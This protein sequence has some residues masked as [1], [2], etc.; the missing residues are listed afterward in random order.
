MIQRI[1]RTVVFLF[2]ALSSSLQAMPPV[3]EP[4]NLAP[5][6]T[7]AQVC[8]LP[9]PSIFNM[10]SA[11]P[12]WVLLGF[13]TV[14]GATGYRILT[15]EVATGITVEDVV[16]PAI[17]NTHKVKNLTPATNY[18][19]WIWSI[20]P[21]GQQGSGSTQ[22]LS[23]TIIIDVVVGGYPVPS[24]CLYEECE[25][26]NMGP[27]CTF[28][29]NS[30]E[31]TY[32]KVFHRNGGPERL[33]VVKTP[34]DVANL[35]PEEN[36]NSGFSFEDVNG[37]YV[38]IS[39]TGVGVIARISA[40][41]HMVAIGELYREDTLMNHQDYRI[42]RLGDCPEGRSGEPISWS[43]VGIQ[44]APADLVIA[45]PNPFT[46]QLDVRINFPIASEPVTIRLF[47][48]QGQ[49]VSAQQEKGG[50]QKYSLQ[51]TDLKPGV[52][53]LR[54]ESAGQTQTIKVVKTR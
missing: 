14:P 44:L 12:T 37:R 24:G 7:S 1:N 42:I 47:N 16:V 18:E 25:L 45:A 2:M 38:L 9:P 5:E 15:K 27:G 26:V 13:N 6:S 49:E 35:H 43:K 46:D 54:V 39:R 31:I 11:G 32:F 3:I 23:S 22:A 53:F 10:I 21:N 50:L 33:F 36:N 48:I 51:T 17:A 40:A 30:A 34:G 19:S 8:N 52:Y 20:C 41:R 28:D 29:W 4:S